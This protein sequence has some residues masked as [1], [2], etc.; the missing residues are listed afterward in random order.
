MKFV[1]LLTGQVVILNQ[2][3]RFG[4]KYQ[5]ID[6]YV[7]KIYHDGLAIFLCLTGKFS[8]QLAVHI[9]NANN[10]SLNGAFYVDRFGGLDS[11]FIRGSNLHLDRLLSGNFIVL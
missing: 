7:N 6:E 3:N 10:I 1:D 9:P 5:S 11:G 4:V 8:T 2:G